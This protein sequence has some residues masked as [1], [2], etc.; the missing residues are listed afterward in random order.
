LTVFPLRNEAD[1]SIMTEALSI[2]RRKSG[3]SDVSFDSL[4]SEAIKLIQQLSGKLWTDY[5]LHDPG[6]TILEQLLYA[7]TDLIY[8]TEFA[9]E[10]YL[11]GEDGSIDLEAQG[12]HEPAEILSCRATTTRDYRKLLLDKVAVADNVWLSAMPEQSGTVQCK[13]LYQLSVKLIQGL[14]RHQQDAAIDQLRAAYLATRNLCE[15][16]GEIKLVENLDYELCA[17]IEVGSDRHPVDI[18]ADIYFAC[19][20]RIASSVK[21]TNY[22]QLAGHTPPLDQLFDGPLTRFGFFMD[23]DLPDHQTEF[24]VS[25]LYSVINSIEG[26]DHVRQLYMARGE[27]RFFDKIEIA[28]PDLAFDLHFPRRIEEIKVVLTTNGRMLP[29]TID[30]LIARYEELNY[31]YHTSRSTPQDRSLLYEAVKGNSRSFAQYFSIQ[32]Q[33]PVSYGINWLGVPASASTEV[34]ARARQL[35]AYLLIFEQLLANFLANLDSIKSLFSLQT[36]PPTSYAVQ[37]L[38]DWQIGD[39]NAVYPSDADRVVRRIVAAFDNYNERKNRLLDFHL[40]LYGE[41]FSQNSLRHF[42]YYYSKDEVEQAI[43]ANKVAYLESIV[44]LGNNRAAAP[45]YSVSSIEHK[46]CG[47]GLR[48]AMLLGFEQRQAHSLTGA[49][50]EHAVEFCPHHDYQQRKADSDELR[51]FNLNELDK[52]VIDGFEQ[53]RLLATDKGLPLYE[54]REKIADTIPVKNRLLSDLLLRD[55]INLERYRVAK[56][57]SSQDYSLIFMIDQNQCWQLGSYADMTT[58]TQTA[59]DLRRFLLLLNKASEGLHIIEHILLRP[60]Q[61]QAGSATGVDQGEDFFSFRISVI[62]PCWTTRCH[63]KQFRILAE[64]TLRLNVPAH[65]FPEIYWLDFGQMVEFEQIY[66]QWLRLK[67]EQV[68]EPVELDQCAQQLIVFL[69]EQR[70]AQQ[71]EF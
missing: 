48:V 7:I 46:R 56:L 59:N 10:D 33:F 44:E 4:R 22:D 14:D 51:L 39:L 3:Q 55:G 42:N 53:P 57:D 35:K 49:I 31:K 2:K 27:D 70:N 71:K 13:G 23:D 62:F 36:D 64:E 19:A 38:N 32:N 26:V 20:R 50:L 41:R 6:I 69:H 28:G 29:I 15:D 16:L 47:F 67:S 61:Q 43:V 25:T 45:D 30:Q 65:I 18:L 52:S 40:A 24:L 66:Q 63:D 21:I 5:N 9:I 54:Y 58:A 12:L 68:C 60:Q 1:G 37:T 17:K 8:R 34:K 11:A